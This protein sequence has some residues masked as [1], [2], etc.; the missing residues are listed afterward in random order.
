MEN[1]KNGSYTFGAANTILCGRRN[2]DTKC[3]A[4]T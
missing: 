4:G 2:T 3:W 1:Y